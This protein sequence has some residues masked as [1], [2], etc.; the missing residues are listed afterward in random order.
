MHSPIST[1]HERAGREDAEA[2]AFVESFLAGLDPKKRD[3][4]ILAV[5]E[6]MT[7]PEVATTLSIPVNTAY[8]RLRAVRADFER[9]LGRHKS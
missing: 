1:P 4:F 6:E 7:I 2:A 8:T 5:L 3:L 9:A